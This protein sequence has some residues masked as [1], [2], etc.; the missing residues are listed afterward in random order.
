MAD[1]EMQKDSKKC[2]ASEHQMVREAAQQQPPLE[3]RIKQIWKVCFCNLDG[4]PPGCWSFQFWK[5]FY[6]DETIT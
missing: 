4:I 1:E 5:I 6:G 2:S 3:R